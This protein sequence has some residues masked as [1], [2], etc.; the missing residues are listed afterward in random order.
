MT[1][2]KNP[3]SI[4]ADGPSGP[5]YDKMIEIWADNGD[6][7]SMQYTGTESNISRVTK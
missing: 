6:N 2:I 4:F 1:K 7:L 5:I 3:K